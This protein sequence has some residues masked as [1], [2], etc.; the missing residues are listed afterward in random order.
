MDACNSFRSCLNSSL[1]FGSGLSR[2]LTAPQEKSFGL[3]W[4]SALLNASISTARR[5]ASLR[6][7]GRDC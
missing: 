7:L 2:S 1:T 6:D 5:M 4:R 3:L